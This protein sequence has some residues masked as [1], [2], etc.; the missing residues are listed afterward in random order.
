MKHSGPIP[1][2]FSIDDGFSP[3]L[4][5]SLNSLVK[6]CSPRYDYEIYILHQGLRQENIDKLAS[7]SSPNVHINFAPIEEQ[8]E[9]IKSD[10][11]GN[12]LRADYFTLTIFFR[13]FIPDMFPQYDKGIYLDGDICVPGDISR[14]F[15]IDLGDN[16]LGA[17][18][19]YSIQDAPP[20]VEYVT[21]A[22][23]VD[24]GLEYI[25]SGV[26]LM[27]LR[28]L[29]EVHMG[30][31]F[32]EL[33][34]KYNF[35]SIA[36]DQDYI[37]AM[38]K[39]KIYFLG[40]EWDAMPNPARPELQNPQLIH[41]NLFEKPW[42]KDGVQYASY[43]WEYATDSGYLEEI[44]AF[45]AA[46]PQEQIEKDAAQLGVMCGRVPEILAGEFTFRKVFDGGLEKRL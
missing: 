16:L 3:W 39:G 17:C 9:T 2:F 29:R 44:K 32:L 43:F 40:P 24:R 19:D 14:L 41:Y 45:K 36:P 15:E 7:L 31:R 37:N 26:L 42:I 4:S 30:D 10:F 33:M 8:Y 20:L 38:C 28:K 5:V 1:V 25:N 21:K 6:N 13:L 23:G 34:G 12:K 11:T 18:P 27:D 22:V 46:Y 35:D